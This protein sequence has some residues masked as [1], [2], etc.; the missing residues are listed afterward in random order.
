MDVWAAVGWG[1]GDFLLPVHEGCAV[2]HALG[3]WALVINTYIIIRA[4]YPYF[5]HK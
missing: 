2:S 3:L 1:L 4:V 5:T